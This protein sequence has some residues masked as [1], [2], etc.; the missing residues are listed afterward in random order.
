VAEH[1]LAIQAKVPGAVLGAFAADANSID[2][3][4]ENGVPVC[5]VYFIKKLA[6]TS[7]ILI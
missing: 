6:F 3:Q 4:I 1:I 5:R 7:Y 2:Y